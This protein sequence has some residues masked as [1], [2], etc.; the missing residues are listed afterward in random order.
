MKIDP[1]THDRSMYRTMTGAVVPRP[2]GWISTTSEDGVDNLAPYSFFNVVAIDPPVLMFAPVDGGADG[3]KDT[4]RNVLDTGAFVVNVV[5]EPVAEA[6]NET[7]AT[8]PPE[9]S[10]FDHAGLERAPSER[11]APP[12]VAEAEIAF[13][14]ELYDAHDVGTSRLILGEVVLAHV[15]DALATDEGKLD[16]ERVDAVGRLAGNWYATTTDR[17]RLERP[18]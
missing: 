8:L 6:M 7:S 4:A 1:R 13:E 16:V 17:F 15:D 3:L 2:I 11:I 10:E 18:D 9:E 5:T 14:C 12:R